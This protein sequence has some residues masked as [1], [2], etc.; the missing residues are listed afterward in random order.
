MTIKTKSKFPLSPQQREVVES[1]EKRILVIAG[2]GSGKTRVLT[3]RVKYLLGE[4]NVSPEGVVCITFTNAAADEMKERLKDVKGIGETFIGTIHSFANRI[5]KQSGLTYELFTLDVDIRLAKEI[6][7]NWTN[8]GIFQYL[9]LGRYT[10]W[11]DQKRKVDVGELD[12]EDAEPARFLNPSEYAE[13]KEMRAKQQD[14]CKERNIITFDELLQHTKEYYATLGA[15]ID[16]VLLDEAQDIGRLE[17]KFI[18][19]LNAENTLYVGDDWQCQPK[20]T[21]VL[22]IDGTEK[23]IEDVKVGDTVVSYHMGDR[24]KFSSISKTKTK[25]AYRYGYEV[26]NVAQRKTNKLIEVETVTGE[27]TRCTPEHVTYA[28]LPENM[29]VSV[30]Y[31]MAN[32][33][34]QYRIGTTTLFNDGKHKYSGIRTRMHQEKC[35]RGWILDVYDNP[36]EAWVDEQLNAT[37]YGIPQI[38]FQTSKVNYTYKDVDELYRRIPDIEGRAKTLLQRYNRDIRY[39]IA[40][41][42]EWRGTQ[43]RHIS[44]NHLFPIESCNIIPDFMEMMVYTP[45]GRGRY[46]PLK[47]VRY[48]EG[49]D[50]VY[51]LSIERYHNYVADGVLTHNCIY[52]FKGADVNIFK[53]EADKP[54]TKVYRLTDNYR[55]GAQIVDLASRIIEQVP[56]RIEKDVNIKSGRTGEVTIDSKSNIHK[57]FDM[58]RND[59]N[60]NDWFVLC[61]SNK[62][63]VKIVNMLRE[64]N[65]PVDTFKRAGMSAQ[66]MDLRMALPSVKVLTVHTAKGLENKN[67]ILYGNFPLKYPSWWNPNYE[68]RRILYVGVTRAREKLILLN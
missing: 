18:E 36:R 22:M 26:L 10:E 41:T 21:K 39:P 3:E 54:E 7:N 5:Y 14:L 51:S 12:P 19:G 27:I 33:K 66:A 20:G 1:D 48:I 65:I 68:E 25:G 59:P 61:R 35:N 31:L 6:I 28:R 2:S 67:V 34:G 32:D 58:L 42:R 56:D 16:Y 52:G 8:L 50:D 64:Q 4:K 40:T 57:Y 11:L 53:R 63:V 9:T 37:V 62:D 29:N 13:F 55:S 46:S 49:E 30:L 60:L 45:D 47:E 24:R 44:S 17:H 43:P 23:N 38:T 15:S